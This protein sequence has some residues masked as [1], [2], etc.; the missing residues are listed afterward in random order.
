MSFIV[1]CTY[2]CVYIHWNLRSLY[3]VHSMMYQTTHIKMIDRSV[4]MKDGTIPKTVD[5]RIIKSMQQSATT[6][7]LRYNETQYPKPLM[8]ISPRGHR[9]YTAESCC[10]Q[11]DVQCISPFT[12]SP[13]ILITEEVILFGFQFIG[14]PQAMYITRVG[15]HVMFASVLKYTICSHVFSTHFPVHTGLTTPL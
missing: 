2:T 14:K 5:T 4:N 11:L 8:G 6:P 7:S 12:S 9:H 15:I 1:I 10:S 13:E 3:K